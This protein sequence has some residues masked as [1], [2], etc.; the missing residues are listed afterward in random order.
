[1][2]AR[3]A[4]TVVF[5]VNGALF[6]SWASRIPALS[7]RAGAS[8]GLLGLALLAPAVG[9]VVTMPIVG[10]LLRGRSS[11]VFVR[12]GLISLTVTVVLP[13]LATDVPSLAVALVLVGVTNSMLD[14]AM[15]AHGI[16]VER[17]SGRPILSSLHAAFSFG[18]FAGAGVGAAATALHV[19][20]TPHL[21]AAALLFG[22]PGLA[23]VRPLLRG[24]SDP[25]A[26]S[27][28]LGRTRLP[29]RLALLGAVCFF[30]LLA[31]GGASDWSA[32]LVATDLG[33][34]AALGA[35][36]YAV[37][38]AGMGAGRLVADGLWARWGAVGL[39]RRS[40]LLAAIGFAAA[41]LVGTAPAAVVGFLALG[42]GLSGV[43]PTLFRAGADQ[44]GVATGGALSLVSSLGYL[45]FMAG[46]P[47]IGGLAELTSLRAA[48]GLL[49]L[50][51]VLVVAL[52]SAAAP[53]A[54]RAQTTRGCEPVPVT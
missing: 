50:S 42:L 21:I 22:L 53:P 26:H 48:T 16:A 52:A 19:S 5:F 29:A 25:D 18:G 17:R 43:V 49:A 33:G 24:D 46:P 34:S 41:L 44:P 39:L 14:I 40:G 9:A 35:V 15:N 54:S 7:D 32:K 28:Q 37:F 4:I 8:T 1:M 23:A 12:L 13:S 47:L 45:G 31:E 10:R 38:S 30:C 6:A 20:P 3:A 2:G 36:A 51:G 11:R 27:P